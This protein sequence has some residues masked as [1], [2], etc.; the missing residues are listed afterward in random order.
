MRQTTD[1]RNRFCALGKRDDCRRSSDNNRRWL[2][3]DEFLGNLIGGPAPT[4]L[5]RPPIKRNVAAQRVTV[6]RQ[7]VQERSGK[8]TGHRSEERRVGKE[9]RSRWSP[10]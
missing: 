2:H 3:R 8:G 1:Q 6:G 5:F 4:V 7:T 9:C 10:Y